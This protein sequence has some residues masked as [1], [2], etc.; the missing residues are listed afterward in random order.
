[1]SKIVVIGSVNID[2]TIY[3]DSFPK[4]GE[5]LLGNRKIFSLGGKGV[6]Q[7][8]AIHKSKGDVT[9]VC[10]I[11][12]DS[13]GEKI[14]SFI[15]KYG[16]PSKINEIEGN[17]SGNAYIFVDKDSNN[18]IVVI[19]GVNYISDVS[20]L[21]KYSDL[22]NECEYIVLQNEINSSMNE[23]IFKTYGKSKMIVFNPAPYKP[24]KNELFEDMY[25]ITPNE[26]ELKALTNTDDIERGA[27]YLL[28]RGVQNIIV[29]LGEKGSHYFSKNESKQFDAFKVNS[30][31]TVAAGDTFLGC[32]VA[33][34]SKD[35][36]MDES[37]RY[38]S[39]GAALSTTKEG[40]A[41][42]IPTFEDIEAFLK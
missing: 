7:A 25:L 17:S 5:T 23:Y 40:A 13:E 24:I 36:S 32:L 29:T 11:G 6:N 4:V 12:K 37:I 10:F 28:D 35:N 9:F 39:A 1:M 8:L 16:L 26:G 2:Y 31:D 14:K 27:K 20:L 15:S 21:K 18:E 42:S 41:S 19:S 22:L 3:V 34:L 30:I 33:S 38:A